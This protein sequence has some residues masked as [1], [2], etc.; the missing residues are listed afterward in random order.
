MRFVIIGR[1]VP[2]RVDLVELVHIVEDRP[3]HSLAKPDVQEDVSFL[4]S[5]IV[6]VQRHSANPCCLQI[7]CNRTFC[8][9]YE[10][11]GPVHEEWLL[12]IVCSLD[13]HRQMVADQ[14]EAMVLV[15]PSHPVEISF[16]GVGL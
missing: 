9:C 8:L 16:R 4:R 10:G 3:H 1:Q 14:E 13:F 11:L 6:R 7:L 12:G 15:W 2:G 5:E